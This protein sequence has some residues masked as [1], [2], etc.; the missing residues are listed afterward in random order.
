V[1]L[2]APFLFAIAVVLLVPLFYR[3]QTMRRKTPPDATREI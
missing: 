2:V 3:W 1:L